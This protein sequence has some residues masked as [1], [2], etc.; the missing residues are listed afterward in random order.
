MIPLLTPIKSTNLPDPNS[1]QAPETVLI[2][3]SKDATSVKMTLIIVN[4]LFQ[5]PF[6]FSPNRRCK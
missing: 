3:F 4:I 6:D 1:Y 5:G 2:Y